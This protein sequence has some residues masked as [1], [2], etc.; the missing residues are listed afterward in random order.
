MTTY[1]EA[2]VTDPA[3]QAALRITRGWV[4]KA[5]IG[6][7]L[8]PFAKAVQI[9]GQVRYV[10][11]DANTEEALL[12]DLLHELEVLAE[13][14]PDKIDTTLIVHPY[15]L[16]DF[17]AYNDFMDVAD[18]ALDERD[19]VG[20][21]Q[22]ASFHPDYEFADSPGGSIDNYT[23]RSPYPILHLLREESVTRAVDAFPD[24]ADI[25]EKNIATMRE[26]GVEGWDKLSAEFG[27]D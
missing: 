20:D 23:N 13:A 7:N 21:I 10:L 12:A 14:S 2:T 11:S 18:A 4:D 16:N 8:C 3:D 17:M 1:T 19:L 5:V 15:V 26:L 9:K 27:N 22:V 6:L 25:Y 24:A